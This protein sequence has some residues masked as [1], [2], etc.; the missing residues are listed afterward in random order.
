MTNE[1]LLFILPGMAVQIEIPEDILDS[2]R[3]T[4][5]EL[6]TEIAVSLY[7]AGRLAIGKARALAGIDLWQFRQLL[8]ARG[9]PHILTSKNSWKT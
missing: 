2:A 9:I 5:S 4:T 1:F 3:L 8:A 7:A 6:K